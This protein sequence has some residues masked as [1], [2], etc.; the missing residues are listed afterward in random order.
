MKVESLKYN[1]ADGTT[2]EIQGLEFVDIDPESIA[3]IL[4]A[5]RE[6]DSD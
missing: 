1:K 5:I 6:G 2:L 3:G 4:Q